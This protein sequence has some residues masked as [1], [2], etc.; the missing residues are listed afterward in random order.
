M[1][2]NNYYVKRQIV[3]VDVT[4]D[5]ADVTVHLHFLLAQAPSKTYMFLC[6]KITC[7]NFFSKETETT[8]SPKK[9]AITFISPLLAKSNVL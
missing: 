3:Y 4:S 7:E 6:F 5:I 1:L 9:S 8:M 2:D